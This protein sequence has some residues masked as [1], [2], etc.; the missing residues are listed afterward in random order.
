MAGRNEIRYPDSSDILRF[1]QKLKKQGDIS[2]QEADWIYSLFTGE[3]LHDTINPDF[4]PTTYKALQNWYEAVA[5]KVG[6]GARGNF[7][8]TIVFS[9]I[10]RLNKLLLPAHQAIKKH[11]TFDDLCDV[12]SVDEKIYSALP[13]KHLF[14]K[15]HSDSTFK[16]YYK[17]ASRRAGMLYY[18]I[19]I[20][21]KTYNIGRLLKQLS[22][23]ITLRSPEDKN[24]QLSRSAFEVM[25]G[26]GKVTSRTLVLSQY[27]VKL[28]TLATFMRHKDFPCAAAV[29]AYNSKFIIFTGKDQAPVVRHALNIPFEEL[30][31]NAVKENVFD[32]QTAKVLLDNRHIPNFPMKKFIDA[33]IKRVD[34]IVQERLA[35]KAVRQSVES[36]DKWLVEAR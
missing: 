35:W 3:R 25:V 19:E 6:Q 15:R 17:M 13:F 26:A 36:E 8:F 10:E 30:V 16:P 7:I 22:P 1:T 11:G 31:Q 5:E 12:I 18:P 34:D 29:D 4:A 2:L 9:D 33:S 27:E 14:T 28:F 20:D 32:K 24:H 23:V 21:G